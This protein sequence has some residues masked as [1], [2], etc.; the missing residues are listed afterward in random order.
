MQ[1][2]N[3]IKAIFSKFINREIGLDEYDITRSII[4]PLH[5]DKKN[6]IYHYAFTPPKTSTDASLTRLSYCSVDSAKV[7]AIKLASNISKPNRITSFKGFAVVNNVMLNKLNRL[8]G[9]TANIL[10]TPIDKDGKYIA[11][12]KKVYQCD[13]GLPYH[14]DLIFSKPVPDGEPATEHRKYNDELIKL[15]LDNNLYFEDNNVLDKRWGGID[16]SKAVKSF[17]SSKNNKA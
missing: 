3:F 4:H 17:F 5:F 13:S 14:A 11:E 1:L 12:N 6:S 9:L 16:I 15:I 7:D 2:P 8:G 10:G